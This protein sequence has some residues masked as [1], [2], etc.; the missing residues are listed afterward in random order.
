MIYIGE[1]EFF[2]H[3]LKNASGVIKSKI[4]SIFGNSIPESDR[5][6]LAT[7]IYY[8]EEKLVMA[9]RGNANIN[10]WY[11]ITLYRLIQVCKD[12]A[13]KYTRSK[14][15]K[16]L[17]EGFDYIINE[18]LNAQFDAKDKERYYSQIINTII[19][20]D[21][22]DAFIIAISKLISRLA[23][24][25]LHILGDIYDRGL[26]P[27]MIMDVLMSYHSLDITWG[28]HDIVWMGSAAGNKACIANALRFSA[29]Y[30][31][32]AFVEEGYGI[33]L[34]PLFMFAMDKYQDDPCTKFIPKT[35]DNNK[36]NNTDKL[37]ASKIH[38]AISILQFKLEGQAIM[39][40]PKYNMEDR[41]LLDKVNYE[42]GIINLR[43]K[44]L[45]IKRY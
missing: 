2:A 17:P 35:I 27:D 32:L 16:A 23:I 31:N 13:S 39:N 8:P 15:R 43:W 28:N 9:K 37:V 25:H 42:S 12:V 30:D 6:D 18:L 3:I 29:R 10:E 22:A 19:E 20:I 5:K 21:R 26:N 44:I 1:Y 45:H 14:V 11:T 40:H 7:L 24:D 4:E 41:L 33:N 36:Y 38:K 34:R